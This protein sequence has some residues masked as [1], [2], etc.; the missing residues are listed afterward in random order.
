M[1]HTHSEAKRFFVEKVLMQARTEGVTLSEV[2]QQML[3]WSE[4]D[5][6]VHLDFELPFRLNAEI[7]DEEYEKKIAGLLG[8]C[9]AAESAAASDAEAEW[10]QAV[11]VLG[12]GDHYIHIAVDQAIGPDPR[13]KWWQFWR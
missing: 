1:V 4:T 5:P 2:E 8:R 10:W 9:F 6:E 12:Q 3:W 11:D 7:S 13:K